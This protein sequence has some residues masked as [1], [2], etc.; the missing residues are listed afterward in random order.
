MGK[1]KE[2]FIEMMEQ[3][4]IPPPLYPLHSYKMVFMDISKPTKKPRFIKI[5]NKKSTHKKDP[6]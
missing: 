3:Q 2:L 5:T 4:N 6:R 1:S